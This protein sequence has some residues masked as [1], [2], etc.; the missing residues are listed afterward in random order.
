MK[1]FSVRSLK[2][3][4]SQEKSLGAFM[5]AAESGKN[6]QSVLIPSFRLGL[7]TRKMSAPDIENDPLAEK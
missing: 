4:D 7:H 1:D 6:Y 2:R 3:I 5:T